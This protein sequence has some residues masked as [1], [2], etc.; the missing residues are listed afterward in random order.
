MYDRIRQK[1]PYPVPSFG[2]IFRYIKLFPPSNPVY[3]RLVGTR[4]DAYTD[5]DLFKFIHVSPED[6]QYCSPRFE[7]KWGLAGRVVEGEWDRDPARYEEAS[8]IEGV[9]APFHRSLESHFV[10]D[11]R[12]EETPFVQQVI[13]RISEG[14]TAWTCANRRD[15]EEK[16]DRVDRLYERIARDGYMTQDQRYRENV[17]DLKKSRQSRIFRWMKRY[18]V[19]GKDE[20]TVNIARDGRFL[21]FSGKHRM[22]I[23]KILGLD[24]VPVLVLARHKEWQEVRD[25]AT[26]RRDLSTVLPSDRLEHPDLRDVAGRFKTRTDS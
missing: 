14:K 22:S 19:V 13:D 15:V 23:A 11:V 1:V 25:A 26:E 21:F 4:T 20:I 10:D 16:C 3:V 18:T 17:Q 7:D 2:R 9:D 6:I 8:F 12:W 24:S 5:A